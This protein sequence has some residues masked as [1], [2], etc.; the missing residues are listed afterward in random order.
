MES[1]PDLIPPCCAACLKAGIADVSWYAEGEGEG[2]WWV[3]H[4]AMLVPVAHGAEALA[5]LQQLHYA[6]PF[7]VAAAPPVTA[8]AGLEVEHHG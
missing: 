7:G 1:R 3:R 8:S 2:G 6:Q 5:M 4:G